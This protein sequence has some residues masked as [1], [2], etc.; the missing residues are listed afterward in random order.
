MQPIHEVAYSGSG[1]VMLPILAAHN[2]M[3]LRLAKGKRGLGLGKRSDE[4]EKDDKNKQSGK[5]DGNKNDEK[6]GTE[7]SNEAELPLFP[8]IDSIPIPLSVTN[9]L[10]STMENPPLPHFFDLLLKQSKNDLN[11]NLNQNSNT[12]LQHPP[13][14]STLLPQT[15]SLAPFGISL[16]LSPISSSSVSILPTGIVRNDPTKTGGVMGIFS[17]FLFNDFDQKD[18]I[19]L[20][21]SYNLPTKIIKIKLKRRPK[22]IETLELNRS[23][24]QDHGMVENDLD[25]DQNDQNDQNDNKNVNKNNNFNFSNH[26]DHQQDYFYQTIGLIPNSFMQQTDNTISD[27]VHNDMTDSQ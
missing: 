22:V 7:S 23:L 17:D 12:K 9:Q 3:V 27:S 4:N 15:P 6:N 8:T 24:L 21:N 1:G 20:Q 5:N 18:I 26:F 2:D 11:Q 19:P 16:A 25:D 10:P 13:S 14:L